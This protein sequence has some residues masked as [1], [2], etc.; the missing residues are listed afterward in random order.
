MT[1]IPDADQETLHSK[2]R[3]GSARRY[4]STSS[5]SLGQRGK[6]T[7][8]NGMHHPVQSHA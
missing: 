8:W 1:A 4:I 7:I 2:R 6:Q 5:R 3:Q